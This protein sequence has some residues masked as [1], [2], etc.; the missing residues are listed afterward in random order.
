MDCLLIPSDKFEQ[1]LTW[2][3]SSLLGS[4]QL[5]EDEVKAAEFLFRISKAQ[6]IDR[7]R[8][9][10]YPFIADIHPT[11]EEYRIIDEHGWTESENL[12]VKAYALDLCIGR[13]KDKRQISRDA[14]DAYMA[15]Y[16]RV[17]SSWFLIR[18]VNVRFFKQGEDVNYLKDLAE[19]TKRVHGSWLE[20]ISERLAK[21]SKDDI[22]DYVE[23]LE[24]RI[25]TLLSQHNSHDAVAVLD[26]LYALKRLSNDEYHLRRAQL[27][28]DEFDHR[29]ATQTEH[30]FNMK[31]DVIEN[32]FK[33]ISKVKHT[34]P[35]DYSRIREKLM[36]EQKAFAEMMPLFG[37]K[38]RYEI[39]PSL[40]ENTNN[41]L[42]ENPMTSSVDLIC[43]L[44]TIKFPTKAIVKTVSR[45]LVQASPML[46][47]SFGASVATGE[48]GQTLGKAE[49]DEALRIEAHKRLRLNIHYICKQS[50]VDFLQ[51]CDTFN[52]DVVGQGLVDSCKA[53]Y[54]EDSR[55]VLWAKGIVA[56]CRGDLITAA[57][58]L[59]PQ[60]ERALV[61]K[62]QQ[63]C[64]DLT[65][66]ERERHDQIGLD[67]A[68]TALKPY[69]KGVLYDE[70]SFFL[71]HG[72]DANL[73][74]RLAHGLIEPEAILEQG[75][76]LWW[77]AIKL[78]FCEKEIFLSR[79]SGKK[80]V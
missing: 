42:K 75:I 10:E 17:K 70:L 36:A 39:P 52:E 79:R 6:M 67:K 41:Y 49:A 64:G 2:W 9:E 50:L 69:L 38:I 74:N 47:M 58:I 34:Y 40:I 53:S 78:F 31:L 30:Q 65:N 28:E 35:N 15:L 44:R 1:D 19:A 32:A 45:K 46:Y 23:G 37:A 3:A 20:R 7:K 56:G 48:N 80:N 8:G 29:L 33:D 60:I 24:E 43:R 66:Y 77:L 14:S 27:Y 55:K 22:R 68:L 54:I 11:P 12:E 72:A 63:F 57:H 51:H 5:P 4:S 59:M 61:I 25:K 16:K 62:A 73:R 21:D 13:E 76:Y 18:S 71:M 26:A